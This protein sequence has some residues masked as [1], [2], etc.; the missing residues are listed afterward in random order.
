M[1][2]KEEIERAIKKLEEL[3]NCKSK[4]D[5]SNLLDIKLKTIYYIL[6]INEEPLY[7][8]F[9]IPKK[10]GGMR[11]ISAPNDHLKIIQKKLKRNLDMCYVAITHNNFNKKLAH[12][13]IRKKSIITNS[14]Y[15]KN[16]RYVLN[17]DLK[18]FFPSINFG[19]VR[20]FFIKNKYFKLNE[21]VATL[22]AQ[23]ACY[24]NQLPQGSPCSPI[25][26]NLLALSL[27]KYL[28]SLS[29]RYRFTYTRYADDITIST[30][31]REFPKEIAYFNEEEKKWFL[32]NKVIE[33][34]N[35]NHFNINFDKIRMQYKTSRQEVTGLVTNKKVNIKRSYIRETRAMLDNL[36]LCPNNT[37]DYIVR[38]NIVEGRIA[39]IN[40]IRKINI[41]KKN[42]K[43]F[44]S[45]MLEKFFCFDN[46]V[47][48]N[49][50]TI[51]VEGITD[52]IYIKSAFKHFKSEYEFKLKI[53]TKNP[54]SKS[55]SSKNSGEGSLYQL[56]S[57]FKDKKSYILKSVDILLKRSK[58]V[59]P[60]NPV[61]IIFDRDNKS[62]VDEFK[63]NSINMKYIFLEPNIYYFPIPELPDK[64]Y[65]S[66][67]Y[68]FSNEVLKTEFKDHKLELLDIKNK[69]EEI[70]Y[71][72]G[73][74]GLSKNRFA[75]HIVRKLPKSEFINFKNIFDIIN[76]INSDYKNK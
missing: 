61:I 67:E 8:E 12:G 2:K 45:K 24:N 44:S 36:I 65:I 10:N 50:I 76:E 17:I 58:I 57:R 19:R 11:N 20:G 4:K 9:T 33:V 5:F 59:K 3:V 22:I 72:I 47:N 25:I 7:E 38:K 29:K 69:D 75:I 14:Q 27:D 74:N 52:K 1:Y 32:G 30:N 53:K 48:N 13:F 6:R 37:E 40:Q 26:S 39:F 18:D 21:D 49:N 63:A 51:L 34:I 46:F 64:K 43:D 54:F 28:F 68:Y 73:E 31:L 62:I 35:N 55:N 60:K 70:F 16:K 71:K 23:I 41:D 42:N 66:I 15:H 56:L